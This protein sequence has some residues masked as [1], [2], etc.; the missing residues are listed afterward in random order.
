MIGGNIGQSEPHI[1][2]LFPTRAAAHHVRVDF[3]RVLRL[4]Y[5]PLLVF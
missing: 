3:T 1:L 2:Y 4:M 5:K